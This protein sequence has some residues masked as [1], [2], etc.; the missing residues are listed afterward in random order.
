MSESSRSGLGDDVVQKLKE[1]GWLALIGF[2]RWLI[3]R[4]LTEGGSSSRDA[5]SEK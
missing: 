5:D 3:E 2:L 1:L 4:L